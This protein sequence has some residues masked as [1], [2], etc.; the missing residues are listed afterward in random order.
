MLQTDNTQKTLAWI[1][2]ASADYLKKRKIA[3][4]NIAAEYLAARL[5]HCH[6]L[7]LQ[8]KLKDV[9]SEKTVEAMRRGVM[10]V[11][12]GE[13]IQY[14]I[15]QWD[16]RGLTLKT[17]KR[18]LIPRPE[19]EELVQLFL[20]DE[21]V[22]NSTSPRV[23]DYGT[24]TGCIALS[25]AKE[26]PDAKIIAV[27]ISEDAISLA[28]ENLIELGLSGNINFFNISQIDISDIL[29]PGTID[30]IV[31][32]PPYIPTEACSKLDRTVKDFEPHEALDGGPDG[33]SVIRSIIEEAVML[34]NSGGMLFLEIS[35]ENNQAPK[36][37]EFLSEIGFDKP[38]VHK[39]SCNM[40]RFVSARLADGL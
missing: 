7:D 25:I 38:A 6:R 35:A 17:D 24:G 1:L 22:K 12:T 29:E 10:R 23:L 19:T 40:E 27:D 26:R 39:D 16:F 31:S 30:V 28:K 8:L 11:G 14:V 4:P 33:M 32:N 13:P 15:G 34:L 37:V 9:L 21:I 20:S 5:L 3:S 2:N 36:L 18:A